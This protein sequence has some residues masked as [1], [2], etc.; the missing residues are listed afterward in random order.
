MPQ[1]SQYNLQHV[2]N[3][4]Q[5]YEQLSG[6]QKLLFPKRMKTAL[7]EYAAMPIHQRTA[8]GIYQAFAQTTELQRRRYS[9]LRRF[10]AHPLTTAFINLQKF[11]LFNGLSGEYYF[12]RLEGHPFP[13]LVAKCFLRLHS[14]HMFTNDMAGEYFVLIAQQAYPPYTIDYLFVLHQAGLS[15]K[16]HR[17]V[18]AAI[19]NPTL[20]SLL[21]RMMKEL[22]HKAL[23]TKDNFKVLVAHAHHLNNHPS[24]CPRSFSDL[25]HTKS[26][27]VLLHDLDFILKDHVNIAQTALMSHD[28]PIGLAMSL[29]ELHTAG[30]MTE[31]LAQDCVREVLVNRYPSDLAHKFIDLSRQ[32]FLTGEYARYC[33]HVV[34]SEESGQFTPLILKELKEAKLYHEDSANFYLSTLF[35]HK[36]LGSLLRAI[37][38]LKANN[39]LTKECY[40]IV[41]ANQENPEDAARAMI[42]IE[43]EELFF[44]EDDQEYY[45][46]IMSHKHPMDVIDAYQKLFSVGL[47][48]NEQSVANWRKM[49]IHP[50]PKCISLALEIFEEAKLLIGAEAQ[51]NFDS[52]IIPYAKALFD[53][54]IDFLWFWLKKRLAPLLTPT[55]LAELCQQPATFGEIR[56]RTIRFLS[57]QPIVIEY[58]R[59]LREDL[60]DS[61]GTAE[62]TLSLAK[63]PALGHEVV[64]IIIAF[65]LI[66]SH[67]ST[68][69]LEKQFC[70]VLEYGLGDIFA[71]F[72][73]SITTIII[74]DDMFQCPMALPVSEVPANFSVLELGSKVSVEQA[75]M[76]VANMP[77]SMTTLYL[78]SIDLKSSRQ[79]KG[80]FAAIPTTVTT[81]KMDVERQTNGELQTI[82]DMLP[83]S[84]T[85]V[86]FKKRKHFAC[87]DCITISRPESMSFSEQTA[88]RDVARA[89]QVNRLFSHARPSVYSDSV[90]VVHQSHVNSA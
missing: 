75:K 38:V 10:A 69:V 28:D 2:Q 55:L 43:Q 85:R 52:F 21:I 9:C 39:Y 37:R 56:R 50:H 65:A 83:S 16:E 67:I 62:T 88:P 29:L 77:K 64:A 23:L 90:D 18:V 73:A 42:K 40:S 44:Y 25:K 11:G 45:D 46:A 30:L 78:H 6:I 3:L 7:R 59:S 12:K 89:Y 35:T 1:S 17:K 33:L 19:S 72:P 15:T 82:L 31:D 60:F 49:I 71:S 53:N 8:L 22:A 58:C 24:S 76:L 87:S 20:L 47:L 13:K 41:A 54:H 84:V 48:S 61:I 80:L 79:L 32:G 4:Q 51:R 57:S 26:A 68:L 70:R 66:P 5:S 36:K 34:G 63:Y 86:F 74:Q 14:H 27:L 81:L